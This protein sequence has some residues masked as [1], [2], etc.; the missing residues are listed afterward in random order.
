MAIRAVERDLHG[1]LAPSTQRA[2]SAGQRAWIRLCHQYGWPVLMVGSGGQGET[3]H[4]CRLMIFAEVLSRSLR[5]ATVQNY[6][7]AVR[8]L[9]VHYL[10]HCSWRGGLR[11][12]RLL[13]GIRRRQN[14]RPKK[15]APV[16]LALLREWKSCFNLNRCDHATLWAAL[17]TAFFGLLRKSEFTV[18]AGSQF[19]PHR[20]LSCGDISFCGD[21]EG[22]QAG[23]WMEVHVKFSKTE[24][25]GA[26]FSIPIA[27]NGGPV[28][29]Y[30]AVRHMLSLR[31]RAT[32]T[33][34][35]FV[36][37]T[38][39]RPLAAATVSRTLAK[40]VQGTPS[41][42]SVWVTPHSLRVG[43]TLALQEA[44]ASELVLQ[45]LGRWRSDCYKEYLRFARRPL[46]QWSQR[47]GGG[48]CRGRRASRG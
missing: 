4:E 23:R 5:A 6:I 16:T 45:I 17:L 40:L 48:G 19:D 33:D 20:H 30:T 9:H 8:S 14:Y 24:Q 27:A 7:S 3:R 18:G 29:A 39:A 13:A 21:L 31:P 36:M 25:F 43:G 34:P 44:G 2:Y 38:E 26:D 11:L 1:G 37:G 12:P 22:E 42:R 47:M 46:I 10:G 41:L 15:R 28:C 32:P 35:L